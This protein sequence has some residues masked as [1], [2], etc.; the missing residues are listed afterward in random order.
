MR[1]E[2]ELMCDA[3]QIIKK[4]IHEYP[5]I[6]GKIMVLFSGGYDSMIVAHVA[7]RLNLPLPVELRSINTQ[8]SAD[9]WIDYVF[10]VA[11]AFKWK[12]EIY[13]NVN[14]FEA[15][16]EFV[17]ETGCP[18]TKA[19]HTFCYQKL[20]ERGF[21]AI[22]MSNKREKHTGDK[23]L[24]LSGMRRAESVERR[25]S[26]EYERIGTT[27][28]IFAAPIVDWSDMECYRYRADHNLPT[29]P[30]YQT[31][32]GSGDCQCN[33]GDFISIGTLI[34]HSPVLANGNVK[35]IDDLSMEIHG[36][37]WDSRKRD[38]VKLFEIDYDEDEAVLTTP[39]LCMNCSRLK[40]EKTPTTERLQELMI[41]TDMFSQGREI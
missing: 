6:Q 33:W 14:G 7:H 3:E 34:E 28:K 32:K 36:Y 10:Q 26:K 40:T 13:E 12:L 38:Q 25:K 18:R 23:T 16:V 30:F 37:G 4:A 29:N 1:S 5:E 11:D 27:N 21:N 20:K 2:D 19:A 24:F 17:K 15:F 9:G 39:F 8:L 31:V 22:H 41:Q 35:I